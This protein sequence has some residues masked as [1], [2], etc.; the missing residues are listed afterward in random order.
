MCPTCHTTLDQSELGG[1]AADRGVHLAAD[2]AV[3]DGAADRVGARRELRSGDS[4]CAAAQGL[5]P[6]R[7]VAADRAACSS[8]RSCSR[9]ASGAGAGGASRIRTSRAGR[10]G[11]TTRRSGDSTSCSH[12]STDG[13]AARRSRS[14]RASSSVITPC[15]LPL[16]PGYLVG[17]LERRGGPAR[18]ARDGAARRRLE[19]PVHPRLHGRLRRA[20]RGRGGDRQRRLRRTRRPRSRASCSSC[21][22]SRSSDC[23][24]VPER[25]LAP[26]L[27]DGARRRGSGVLLG[28][29]FAVCA[30]PCIGTRARRRA[31]PR[32][33]HGHGAQGRGA[34]RRVR[35]RP[36]C[37][38]PRS[39]GSRSRAR[40][41]RSA[42]CATTTR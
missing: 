35:A 17:G 10:P 2:R 25:I 42:G 1:R 20:R 33:Q 4:R 31:R 3:R 32:E 39:P 18:R 13:H 29:A 36:G 34:A 22:G 30:A 11:S 9:S 28:G 8:A 7:V 14:P 23:C 5:R 41:A 16:V 6:A 38:V 21:S 37:G 15:V 27:L 26:G 12:A 19:P 24:P 40:W